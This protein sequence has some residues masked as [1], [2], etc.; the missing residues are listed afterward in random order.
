MRGRQQQR[1]EAYQ[2]VQA[3]LADNP[4]AEPNSYGAPKALLD[5]VVGRLTTHGV[6]QAAGT[7][8]GKADTQRQRV[9]RRVLRQQHLRPIAQ[10]AKAVLRYGPGLDR[11]TR[12]P[13]AHMTTTQLLA[14]ARAI[15]VAA[16]PYEA[17]FVHHGR[18]VDFLARLDAAIDDLLQAQLGHARNMGKKSGASAGIEEE[19]VRGRQAVEMLD[20]IITTSFFEDGDVLAKWRSARRIRGGNGDAR[21]SV[22]SPPA[23]SAASSELRLA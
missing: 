10:I 1:V 11:A 22:E 12:M 17:T 20:A 9:L 18:A 15:R 3:F 8:M 2:R 19:I 5:D 7:R 21:P 14:E 6:D 16:A 4:L 13:S 23:E